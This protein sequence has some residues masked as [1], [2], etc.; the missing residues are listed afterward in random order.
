MILTYCLLGMAILSVW[1]PAVRIVKSVPI[2]AWSVLLVAAIISALASGILAPAALLSL[3]AFIAIAVYAERINGDANSIWV[4]RL[5][6]LVTG[7]LALALALHLAPGFRNP[8]V[9]DKVLLSPGAAPLTQYL[10]FDK[11]VVGLVLFALLCRK[12]K[13][14]SDFS[15][16]IR[17]SVPAMTVTIAAVIGLAL[18]S[19]YVKPDLK[20]PELALIFLP[21]NLLFTCVAEE[22]FFRGFLQ[23]QIS[24]FFQHKR[25]G[26]IVAVVLAGSLFG[27][28]HVGGG[29]QLGVLATLAGFGYG[30]VYAYTKRIEAAIAAHFALN[31]VQFLAFTY[32]YLR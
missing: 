10:N 24:A 15:A 17:K 31:A 5:V 1:F 3:A 16:A 12:V 18:A 26:H 13:N 27:A 25:G 23:E 11:G 6:F 7:V 4:K 28:A 29:W 20:F 19:G 21:V 8:I 22:A 14:L 30:Y 2:P 9:I 32:P